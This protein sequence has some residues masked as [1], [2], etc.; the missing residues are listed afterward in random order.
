MASNLGGGWPRSTGN[1]LLSS[2]RPLPGNLGERPLRLT[3]GWVRSTYNQ[4]S[5]D[6]VMKSSLVPK[7]SRADRSAECK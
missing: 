2:A 5:L 4:L 7:W 3:G 1:H 6:K